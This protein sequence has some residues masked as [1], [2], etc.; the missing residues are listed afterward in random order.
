MTYSPPLK[1]IRFTL[2]EVA[3]IGA[4]KAQSVYSELSDD[5]IES[6]LSEA[7]KI[8]A[9]V[10][11]PLNSAG[12][13]TPARLADG[14]VRTS[15]GFKDAYGA[16]SAGGWLGLTAD[17]D[18]GGAGLPHAVACAVYEMFNAGN[19]SLTLGPILAMGAIDAISHHASD[20]LKRAYLPRI[21]SGEW[22]ATMNL[23]EP[24]AGSDLSDLKT[25]AVPQA[26]G[27]YRLFGSKIFISW[28]E[29]DLTDNIIHLV[30]AR[31][32]DAPEGSR[33]IS[34]FL[35]PKVQV[36]PDG[37]LGA[38]NDI[39]CTRLEEKMGLHGSPT[40][41]M[42]Y[43]E[44]D[45][46]VGY[47]IGAENKGLAA[48]FTM[49]NAER[50]Y[51]G[52]QGVGVAERAYQ[53]AL[54]YARDRRQ[55][56]AD[57]VQGVARL[58]DHPDIRRTLFAMKAKIEGAR[59]ICYMTAIAADEAAIEED[60]EDRAF[61]KRREEFL[62][63]I[64]KA[65]STDMAVEVTS[66]GLQAHG[67]MGYIEETGAAQYCRDAR[68]FAIY[69]GTN[70][71]QAIDLIS[72]KLTLGGGSALREIIE[73]IRQS[74]EDCVTSSS[75]EL[76]LIGERLGAAVAAMESAA[77][78]LLE[79]SAADRR[80]ALAGATP[81]LGL[82]GDVCAGWGL[83]IAAV[84]AYRRLKEGDS[85]QD[86][87]RAK[88]ALARF[89]ADTVLVLAEGKATDVRLGAGILFGASEEALSSV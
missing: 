40:C 18:F 68:V 16:F 85:D 65:W 87:L 10:L 33:G 45:G 31:T 30:L 20:E 14:G 24:Q 53:A 74:V 57:G 32:P 59:A 41:A 35:A 58:V 76:K 1:D 51:V 54:A 89:F 36:N 50:L 29:H 4:L 71:I 72:R 5:L 38:R 48:M 7:G 26:D 60:S 11:A 70:G 43:G 75:G 46:A 27:S 8:A 77:H 17:P 25:R 88:I 39:R 55:G 42:T 86:F 79:Q 67:G 21:V 52:L 49:M 34:L 13:K 19:V 66:L 83:T 80:A 47:L 81:F 2:D 61:A 44:K 28:G 12:D 78:W 9:E 63:P 6:V 23:T 56:R 15:P 22:L 62:T 3:A 84:A 64:A 37:S 73:D 69:E 82:S